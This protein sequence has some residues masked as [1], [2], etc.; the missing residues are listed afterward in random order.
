MSSPPPPEMASAPTSPTITG[1]SPPPSPPDVEEPPLFETPSNDLALA[2]FQTPQ[3]LDRL[4]RA[5]SQHDMQQNLDP[6][7]NGNVKVHLISPD[8]FFLTPGP[9]E[10]RIP[11]PPLQRRITSPGGTPPEQ[12]PAPFTSIEKLEDTESDGDVTPTPAN[13]APAK[14]K[15]KTKRKKKDKGKAVQKEGED[16]A[17]DDRMDV[18][19]NMDVDE[20]EVQAGWPTADETGGP[21]FIILNSPETPRALSPISPSPFPSVLEPSPERS[22][23]HESQV[24]EYVHLGKIVNSEAGTRVEAI[25]RMSCLDPIPEHRVIQV[26]TPEPPA[27]DLEDKENIPPLQSRDQSSKSVNRNPTLA[28]TLT[29]P[30]SP[31]NQNIIPELKID[32]PAPTEFVLPDLVPPPGTDLPTPPSTAPIPE[33]PLAKLLYPN[34]QPRTS[35]R[36]DDPVHPLSQ[37]W[38]LFFSDS[39]DKARNAR[40]TSSPNTSADEY[41]SGLLTI[42][43][44]STLEDLLGGWKALRRHIASSKKRIIEPVGECMLRGTGGLGLYHMDDD[45]NF[46]LFVEGVKP[47]W[48]DRMCAR[49]GKLMFAG[50]GPIVRSSPIARPSELS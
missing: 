38:T 35:P 6:Q 4:V 5:L 29:P 28:M 16:A 39:S 43:T 34:P 47:M 26:M 49:G 7:F 2:A 18:D 8:T 31:P 15:K 25:G 12:S 9:G 14:K 36:I 1:W 24:N 48:E 50:T 40:K 17:E 41:S 21:S 37:T 22:L 33:A 46:H 10:W 27:E 45:T 11:S 3:Q 44:A 13:T 19:E 32:Y 30:P 20:P 42:F 23:P